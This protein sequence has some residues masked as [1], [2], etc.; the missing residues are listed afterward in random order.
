[1]IA[2]PRKP[3]PPVAEGFWDDFR[4]ADELEEIRHERPLAFHRLPPWPAQG[5]RA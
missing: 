4:L 3:S 1:M 5:A 2:S